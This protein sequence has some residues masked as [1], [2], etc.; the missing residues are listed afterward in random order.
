M[1]SGRAGCMMAGAHGLYLP[2]RPC[3][4]TSTACFP[5][6]QLSR[7]AVANGALSWKA[8]PAAPSRR[9]CP[10]CRPPKTPC[11]RSAAAWRGRTGLAGGRAGQTGRTGGVGGVRSG[12]TGWRGRKHTLCDELL[13]LKSHLAASSAA[14]RT[15]FQASGFLPP[16]T[17]AALLHCRTHSR[18]PAGPHATTPPASPCFL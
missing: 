7:A 14:R 5:R 13:R 8:P 17:A 2:C 16:N 1:G 18:T 4:S 3:L 11:A 6:L 9:A 10:W 15:P 12:G